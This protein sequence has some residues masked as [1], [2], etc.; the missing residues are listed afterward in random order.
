MEF[1]L[2]PTSSLALTKK[3]KLG[4][5]SKRNIS[6]FSCFLFASGGKIKRSVNKSSDF[7][8]LYATAATTCVLMCA[9]SVQTFG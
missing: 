3:E 5:K 6:C 4:R 8:K 7:L 9:V 2:L 1:S